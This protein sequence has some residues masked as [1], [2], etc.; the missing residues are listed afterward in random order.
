MVAL[1]FGMY[2]SLKI[3]ENSDAYEGICRIEGIFAVNF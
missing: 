1:A 2:L 3:I